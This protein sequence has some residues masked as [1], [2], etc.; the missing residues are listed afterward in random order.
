MPRRLHEVQP[1]SCARSSA[2]CV[3]AEE[4]DD[5]LPIHMRDDGL[6]LRG[7]ETA[8]ITLDAPLVPTDLPPWA[9]HELRTQKSTGE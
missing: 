2:A 4:A 9:L 8:P 1:L 7:H 5:G 6:R 3:A